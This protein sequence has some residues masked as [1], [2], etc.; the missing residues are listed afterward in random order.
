MVRSIDGTGP[1]GKVTSSGSPPPPPPMLPGIPA[2]PP[3]P[4]PA[5]AGPRPGGLGGLLN[6]MKKGSLKPPGGGDDSDSEDLPAGSMTAMLAAKKKPLGSGE[7]SSPKAEGSGAPPSP[8]TGGSPLL[9]PPPSSMGGPPPPILLHSREGHLH[10]RSSY[11]TKHGYEH[12]YEKRGCGGN[13]AEGIAVGQDQLYGCRKHGL[14]FWWSGRERASEG[15]WRQW[16]L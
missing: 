8:K 10:P 1:G 4:P 3:P 11:A 6:S 16:R 9:P 5:R 7:P 12:E 14:R 15:S 13:Q 2:P